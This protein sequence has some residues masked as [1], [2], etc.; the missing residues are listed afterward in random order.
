[1]QLRILISN[2]VF[3]VR[4]I[5]LRRNQFSTDD[6]KTIPYFTFGN[7]CTEVLNLQN[8]IIHKHIHIFLQIENCDKRRSRCY[9][10]F[11]HDIHIHIQIMHT[12]IFIEFLESSNQIINLVFK[13]Q[14]Q[15]KSVLDSM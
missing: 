7:A 11:L 10:C 8:Q 13:Q 15:K 9:S 3:F 6:T 14:I 5:C 12:A 2:I 1:M 4:N